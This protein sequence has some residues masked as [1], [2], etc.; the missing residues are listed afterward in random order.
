MI[1]MRMV[2]TESGEVKGAFN[3]IFGSTVRPVI[4]AEKLS[5]IILDKIEALY[6]LR[7]KISGKTRTQL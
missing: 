4:L 2:D 5:E 6:P 3:D 1:S 7:G